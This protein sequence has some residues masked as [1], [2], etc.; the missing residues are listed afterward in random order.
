MPRPPV[1]AVH[2][3]LD[4][5]QKTAVDVD[6]T[7]FKRRAATYIESMT[8]SRPYARAV[9]LLKA[10]GLRTTR[11][12]IALAR[13]LFDSGADRRIAKPSRPSTRP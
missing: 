7:P 6:F 3:T 5:F 4:R 12:R 1:G 11:Q 13:L 2:P 10:K 8:R 9:G